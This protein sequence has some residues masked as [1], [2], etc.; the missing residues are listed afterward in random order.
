MGKEWDGI[1]WGIDEGD[2]EG[3]DICFCVKKK[4]VLI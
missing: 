4:L 3:G 1:G 2:R